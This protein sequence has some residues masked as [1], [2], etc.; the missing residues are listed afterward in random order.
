MELKASDA[1]EA[2]DDAAKIHKEP[3]ARN[4]A[5]QMATDPSASNVRRFSLNKRTQQLS[6]TWVRG[7]N[8]VQKNQTKIQISQQSQSIQRNSI[9]TR[10]VCNQLTKSALPV[11]EANHQQ[12]DGI[13]H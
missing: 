8:S 1:E 10:V 12:M 4:Q 3:T 7:P 13:F 9:P 6:L 2:I 11:A 5:E